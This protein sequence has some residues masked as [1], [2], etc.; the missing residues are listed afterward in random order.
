M[1]EIFSRLPEGIS[2]AEDQ[3]IVPIPAGADSHSFSAILVDAHYHDLILNHRE[4]RDGLAFATATA[5]IPLKVKAWLDLSARRLAGG[6]I[7]ARDIAKHRADVFRLAATLP[8]DTTVELPGPI[9]GDVAA[10]LDAFPEASP[11]WPAILSAIKHTVG[12]NLKPAV[13]RGAIR[14]FFLL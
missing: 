14:S 7:D 9:R 5:L 10:F 8:G 12:G 4:V 3:T 11:E 6:A 2:P 13:L 1:L